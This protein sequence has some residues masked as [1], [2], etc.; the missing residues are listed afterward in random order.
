MQTRLSSSRDGA[1]LGS[2]SGCKAQRT[3]LNDLE[4]MRQLQASFQLVLLPFLIVKSESFGFAKM[5]CTAVQ[6]HFKFLDATEAPF[7]G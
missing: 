6:N 2:R 5:M 3:H 7:H 1:G 4:H